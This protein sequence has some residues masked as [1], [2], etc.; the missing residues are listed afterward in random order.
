MVKSLGADKVIDYTTTDFTCNGESY[1]L[2]FDAV[3]KLSRSR[4][5]GSLTK[6]GKYLNVLTDSGASM[7]IKVADLITLKNYI[8]TGRLRSVI[9]RQYPLE[10]IVEAHRYVDKGHKRGNVIITVVD[11][12]A[13]ELC[14]ENRG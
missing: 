2:I 9:D 8:E 13:T 1:D 4:I 3:G 6:N 7:K 10:Q 11:D 14:R 5:K 12:S